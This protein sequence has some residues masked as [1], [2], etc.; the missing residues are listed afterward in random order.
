[1]KMLFAL[2]LIIL[3]VPSFAFDICS[4]EETSDI[5]LRAEKVSKNSKRFTF[6]EKNLVHRTVS[7][8]SHLQGVGRAEAFELFTEESSEGEIKYYSIDGQELIF[9]HYYPGDNE[10]GAFYSVREKGAPKLIA[11][12]SDSFITCVEE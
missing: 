10:F 4:Y 7:L 6:A 11:S 2:F 9:V 12:V 3:S 5:E 1:M 8:E